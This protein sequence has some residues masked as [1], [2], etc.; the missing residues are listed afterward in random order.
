MNRRL[1]TKSE[2]DSTDAG[3][4]LEECDR[5]AI[6]RLGKRLEYLSLA[7][8]GIEGGASLIAAVLAGSTSL[9][10]FGIDSLIEVCSALTPIWRLSHDATPEKRQKAERIS[11]RIVGCCFIALAIYVG[12]EA[13]KSLLIREQTAKS[14]LGIAVALASIV[15]MPLLARAK[16]R[17]AARIR[18]DALIADAKQ[19][20]ICAYLAMI[21]L[22][23]LALNVLFGWWWADAVTSLGM[24][25]IIAIEA[26]RALRGKKC[27]EGACG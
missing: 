7:W 23:G 22:L 26:G 13:T 6:A 20:D 9:L 19:T 12:Y 11:L 16:R 8:N 21:L 25:P 1:R 3:C 15:V 18:S 5:A 2:R 10:A 4:V 24:T 27:C 14:P 17:V